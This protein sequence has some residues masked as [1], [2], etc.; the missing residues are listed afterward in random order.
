MRVFQ[1]VFLAT[2]VMFSTLTQADLVANGSFESVTPPTAA[3]YLKISNGNPGPIALCDCLDDWIVV[4]N[5]VEWVEVSN[6]GIGPAAD[7][8]HYIDLTL[9]ADTG[10]AGIKQDLLT[11]V[12]QTYTLSFSATSSIAHGRSGT[13]QVTVD[14]ADFTQTFNITNYQS[15]LDWQVY[16]LDFTASDA[17]TTLQFTNTQNENQHFSFIDNVEVVGSGPLTQVVQIDIKPGSYPNSI[18]LCS[19]GAVPIAIFG[20]ETFDVYEIDTET[21]RFAEASVKVVGKKDPRSLCSYEYINDDIFNDLVCHFLTA[22]IAGVDG[23]S[24][25][26]TVNGELF[27]G[28]LI[29]GTDG[30][31][32]VK[33]TCN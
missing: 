23:Q 20:S 19:N 22:D 30:V 17:I 3:N 26:A 31:N 25:L 5:G 7:G 11:V 4:D 2:Y 27:D 6:L 18:N 12:G 21:L 24:S 15:A 16:S 33:D 1:I 9:Y 29:K 14:V 8:T 10:G 28:T 32:I 13:G